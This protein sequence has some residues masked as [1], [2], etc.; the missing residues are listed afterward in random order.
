MYANC[1]G[2]EGVTKAIQIMKAE[3]LA[4]A[5]NAGITDLRN[6]S[7]SIV[8]THPFDQIIWLLTVTDQYPVARAVSVYY[9]RPVGGSP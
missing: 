2:V 4:D 1:Y 8:R 3:I 5:A 6:V 7:S 9:E